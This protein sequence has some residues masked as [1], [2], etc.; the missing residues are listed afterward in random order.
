MVIVRSQDRKR[1]LPIVGS[2][3]GIGWVA[4]YGQPVGLYV[5]AP[6]GKPFPIIMYLHGCGNN[7]IYP[8]F[9][10]ISAVNEMEPCAVLLPYAPQGPD[11]MC[12]DW[13]GTY[14][15][16]LRPAMVD[17]LHDLDGV[18]Q[19]YG[20]DTKREYL[21]GESMGGEGVLKLL[22]EYPSRFAGTVAV[23]GYT[24]DTGASEMAETRKLTVLLAGPPREPP[25]TFNHMNA[26]STAESDS[27]AQVARFLA[28]PITHAQRVLVP[29]AD[30]AR[31]LG[32]KLRDRAALRSSNIGVV[33]DSV[34]QNVALTSLLGRDEIV[35]FS[36]LRTRMSRV[37]NV[38]LGK[39][40]ILAAAM[41]AWSKGPP[42]APAIGWLNLRLGEIVAVPRLSALARL[43]EFERELSAVTN[44]HNL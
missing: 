7:P 14:D 6:T 24:V 29:N 32:S 21:Y 41:L 17:A 11:A 20:F 28:W 35:R 43:E 39:G 3:V 2:T 34:T 16:D 25:S 5:P 8:D 19:A 37:R 12:A 4:D 9:W 36:A 13:G 38:N 33:I 40:E 18:I 26:F 44:Q 27:H 15:T 42:A 31:V 23:A 22:V 30:A 10:I 1:G